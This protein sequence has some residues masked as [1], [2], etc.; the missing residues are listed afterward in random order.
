MQL[1]YFA[2]NSIHGEELQRWK[3]L[4]VKKKYISQD[5]RQM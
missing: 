5:K 2:G 1:F 4:A 3:W